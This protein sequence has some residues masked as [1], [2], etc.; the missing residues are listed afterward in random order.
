MRRA[1]VYVVIGALFVSVAACTTGTTQ[2]QGLPSGSPDVSTTRPTGPTA[3]GPTAAT[4]PTVTGEGAF[5]IEFPALPPQIT[6]AAFFTCDSLEGVW[7]YVFQADFG[8]GIGFDVDTTVDMAGGDG[9]LVFGGEFNVGGGNIVF[10]D[11]VE[12][13]IVGTEEAPAL[14]ATSVQVDVSYSVE[15]FPVEFFE[16]FTENEEISIVP[17][18]D[19]C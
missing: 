18:S 4:G 7:R 9:T 17:G 3:T 10:S 2:V 11:T 14:V 8:Q 19:R 12:L 5:S 16:T 15:G 1:R 6:D 13:A